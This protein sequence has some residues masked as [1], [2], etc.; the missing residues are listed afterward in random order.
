MTGGIFFLGMIASG[1]GVA[2]DDGRRVGGAF[3]VC[4]GRG[5]EAPIVLE[6]EALR[7]DFSIGRDG[8]ATGDHDADVSIN[9]TML[10]GD[11]V[12]GLGLGGWHRGGPALDSNYGIGPFMGTGVAW[13]QAEVARYVGSR[14]AGVYDPIGDSLVAFVAAGAIP[15]VPLGGFVVGVPL[16]AERYF[17][18]WSRF[19]GVVHKQDRRTGNDDQA[20]EDGPATVVHGSF[21]RLVGGGVL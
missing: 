16:M 17:G 20:G 4:S 11:D 12:A 8:M 6:N 7:N 18:E 19:P 5:A 2:P 1:S 13:D 21:Y 14:V 3:A 15:A 10:L 9:G